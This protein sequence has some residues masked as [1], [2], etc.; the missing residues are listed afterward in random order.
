[1]SENL[2]YLEMLARYPFALRRFFASSM[3][4]AQAQQ[5][6][7]E[8]V[9]NR[10]KNFLAIAER[11]I[12]KNPR[13]PYLP[14]L[15]MAHCQLGDLRALVQEKGLENALAVLREEGVYFT[16]EEFKGRAPIVRQGKTLAI[17]PKDFDNPAV[18]GELRSETG[19]ST[20]KPTAIVQDMAQNIARAPH[21]LITLAA[22]QVMDAPYLIWRGI[23]PDAGTFEALLR[24]AYFK[25]TTHRW[26]SNIGLRDSNHWLKYG[27]ATYYMLFWARLYRAPIPF[28]EYVSTE[29]AAVIARVVAQTRDEYGECVLSTQVSRAL[30]VCL[31]AKELGIRLDRVTVTAGGEPATP[32]KVRA[33]QDSGA[34]LFSNYSLRE[35]GTLGNACAAASEPGDIHFFQDAHALITHPHH[36]QDFDITVPAFH[37]TTLL[38][39]APKILLNLQMDDYGDVEQ[40]ACGCELEAYGFTT[41]LRNI[42]SY[43]KLTG[44]GV[45]LIGSEMVNILE[46]VLPARF[47][48][49]P[50]DYQWQELEDEQG[51][52][53]L[54]L[55]IHPRLEIQNEQAVLET[56]HQ[57]LAQHPSTDSARAVWEQTKTLRI[58]RGEPIWTVHGKLL[59]LHLVRKPIS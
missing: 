29:N 32:T 40:R 34:R 9:A 18:R 58:K 42:R 39:T 45:T 43:R 36:I 53:R 54:Y 47:G 30:R 21:A 12:Y 55:V 8:R 57:A 6:V 52:T 51:L 10:E 59:P 26:F 15:E 46:N 38:D 27:L 3:T 37:L 7:R 25:Q 13:S 5:I 2:A 20:G 4:L 50:L 17:E 49:S 35:A 1:M 28:P 14:L 11:F 23:L 48:G 24:R 22:Y 16:F 44:E 56:V 33:I 41:H 31:A 19:G